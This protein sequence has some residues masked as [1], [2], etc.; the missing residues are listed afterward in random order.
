[1]KI[2]LV[3]H[4]FWPH[5]AGTEMVTLN[6]ARSLAQTHEVLVYYRDHDDRTPGFH[7][8][9]DQVAGLPVHRVTLNLSGLRHNRYRQFISSYRN[10]EIERDFAHTLERFRPDVVHFQHLMY[11]SARLPAIARRQDIPVAITLHDYWFKCNNAL[12]LRYTG[13]ICHDNESF[14]AC[15]DCAT[16]ARR[17]PEIVRWLM[18]R[19]LQGR[20]RLLREALSQAQVIIAPSEFLKDQFVGDGYAPEGAIQVVENGVDVTGVLPHRERKA[21]E[22]IRFAYIGSIVPHKGVHVLVGA[23]NQV[24]GPARLDIYGDLEAN[25][26]YVEELRREI[27]HPAASLC[28]PVARQDVWRVLSE[29][30]VLVVPSL[31]YEANSPLVVREALAAG[32]PVIASDL[33][34]VPEKVQDGV[35]GLLFPPG[36]SQ[37]L[38]MTLQ[39]VVDEPGQIEQMRR[40]ICLVMTAAQNAQCVESIYA[41]LI[42]QDTVG[43]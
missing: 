22:A 4:R 8:A 29:T 36:H 42:C 15:A 34:S 14:R 25:P 21:G 23:F 30:D 41:S 24:H 28:G 19:V 10:P 16:G 20:D 31:W 17:R 13:E 27:S 26:G 5:L 33:G 40:G 43:L 32:V 1:M 7:A 2:L 18:A 37:A 39:S 11:L 9:D 35:N 3:A 6:L 38:R 12:L